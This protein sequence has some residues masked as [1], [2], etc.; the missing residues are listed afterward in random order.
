MVRGNFKSV[1]LVGL[2]FGLSYSNYSLWLQ[3]HE[4]E[5][6][7]ASSG[8]NA[9]SNK[10][11][12]QH[13]VVS[14]AQI[15]GNHGNQKLDLG[16]D[17]LPVHQD[18]DV[19]GSSNLN[20][21]VI[22]VADA[23]GCCNQC[24][25]HDGPNAE[26][27]LWSFVPP[28]G[29]WLK[30]AGG[31]LVPKQGVLTGLRGDCQTICNSDLEGRLHVPDGA[32]AVVRA[33]APAAAAAAAPPP[34]PPPA[35]DGPKDGLRVDAAILCRI[36]A[37]DKAKWTTKEL[38]QW[39]RYMQYAGVRTVY[40]Y[41]NHKSQAE[42]LE[43]WVKAEFPPDRVVYHD[44]GKYHPFSSAGTQVR[45][46]Q[47]A[48]DNYKT[49]SDFQINFDMDE[50]PFAPDDRDPGFLLR[51]LGGLAKADTAVS[52]FSFANFLFLGK[53][54]DFD[55]IVERVQRRT[56]T[57]A[58]K[59][60]KPIFRPGNVAAAMH[61]TRIKTG[62]RFDVPPALMRM[63]HYWGSRKQNWGEDTQELLDT[64]IKDSSAVYI[65]KQIECEEVGWG[66]C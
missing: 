9:V 5:G 58:S 19:A 2:I 31:H 40:L 42:S 15:A 56:P 23:A 61:H 3:V 26:C 4:N 10:Q 48:I 59:L 18:Y 35:W 60:A 38:G 50:Y 7:G 62:T 14:A 36:Y 28:D 53:W 20:S 32:A 30:A 52:E 16:G 13:R 27:T 51:V 6:D 66:N 55:H 41:D 12:G 39:I 45:A 49:S 34:P 22:T 47:D 11:M 29:C 25:E 37:E 43:A 64:T 17:C 21:K 24:N 1:V 44:W 8:G 57:A 63:N 46:Y 33:A 54:K 65:V